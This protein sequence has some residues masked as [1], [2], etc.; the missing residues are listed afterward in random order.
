M[1]QKFA[2]EYEFEEHFGFNCTEHLENCRKIIKRIR[3]DACQI[4]KLNSEVGEI[5]RFI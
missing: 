3:E 2:S 5:R 4:E 1:L